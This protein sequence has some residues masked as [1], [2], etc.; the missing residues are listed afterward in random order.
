[1]VQVIGTIVLIAAVLFGGV[2]ATYAAAQNSLP[3]DSLYGV[4]LWSE[5]SRLELT[6]E[7]SSQLTLSLKFAD[8]RMMEIKTMLAAGEIPPEAVVTRYLAQIENAM[9]IAAGM[10]DIGLQAGI[11]QIQTHLQ[12]HDQEMLQLQLQAGTPGDQLKEQI[13]DRICIQLRL[14]GQ[15][16]G[17]PEQ[18]REQLRLQQ[19]ENQPTDI[20]RQGT[21]NGDGYGPGPQPEVTPG[22]GD[23]YGPGPQPSVTPGA[24]GG[25][26]PGPQPSITPGAGD[27][28][29]PGPGPNPSAT[30]DGSGQGS[31]GNGNKP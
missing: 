3:E 17:D 27:G 11:L 22:A 30:C 4:K 2:G 9:M 6:N 5:D 20:P 24:G 26:G 15:C 7:T 14:I 29:G 19:Q 16:T 25:Y 31:G 8:R 21:P 18:L 10:D 13:R 12:Q 28:Y 23:G 1:M